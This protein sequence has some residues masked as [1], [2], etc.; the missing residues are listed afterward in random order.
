M[1]RLLEN[2]E[3]GY[4]MGENAW[5]IARHKFTIESYADS[6]YRVLSSIN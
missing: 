6:V 5:Q 1:L 4:E 3:F 2:P